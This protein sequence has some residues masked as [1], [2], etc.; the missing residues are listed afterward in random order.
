MN[1]QVAR[2]CYIA[3]LRNYDL[4]EVKTDPEAPRKS[5]TPHEC[6]MINSTLLEVGQHDECRL[7]LELELKD[8][9]IHRGDDDRTICIGTNLELSDKA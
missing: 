6:Q 3:S 8:F 5:K 7:E 1:Q 4:E 9:R 2:R